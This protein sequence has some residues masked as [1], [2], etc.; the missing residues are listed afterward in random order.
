[1]LGFGPEGLGVAAAQTAEES[2]PPVTLESIDGA[3]SQDVLTELPYRQDT[4]GAFAERR[5]ALAEADDAPIA[6]WG[7]ATLVGAVGL[8]AASL[9]GAA[10]A[11]SKP[12]HTEA[13]R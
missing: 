7:S 12:R 2:A 8:G 3:S 4:A 10:A 9:F 6:R 13:S 11:A 5:E 1:M